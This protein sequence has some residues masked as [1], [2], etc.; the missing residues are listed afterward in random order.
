MPRVY[1]L[2][3]LPGTGKTTYARGL[4]REIGAVCLSHDEWMRTLFGENPPLAMFAENSA[5]IDK[6]IWKTVAQGCKHDR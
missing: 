6:I 1:L 4:E 5:K 3:G 2:H